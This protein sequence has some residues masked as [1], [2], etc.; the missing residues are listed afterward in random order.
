MEYITKQEAQKMAL[1]ITQDT[2]INDNEFVE[3]FQHIIDDLLWLADNY[4]IIELNTLTEFYGN[5]IYK[6]YRKYFR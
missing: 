4:D 5:I 3:T 6:L 1:K 2:S